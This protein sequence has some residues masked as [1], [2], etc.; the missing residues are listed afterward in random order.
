MPLSTAR[1]HG[2][3]PRQLE[4]HRERA[5][6]ASGGRAVMHIHGRGP[7]TTHVGTRNTVTRQPVICARAAAA[8]RSLRRGY[9]SGGGDPRL[10]KSDIKPPPSPSA[11]SPPRTITTLH[12]PPPPHPLPPPPPPPSPP[13]PPP[14]P[15]HRRRDAAAA[16]AAT[17]TTT[18]PTTITITTPHPTS[19]H[20]DS[21]THSTAT[22]IP[23]PGSSP[24]CRQLYRTTQTPFH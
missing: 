21:P 11:P 8:A 1:A 2:C 19:T 10:S 15:G 16:A 7:I 17:A 18:T 23:H 20:T 24:L 22:I 3:Y 12:V 14:P 13:P 4:L 9:S 5:C 6:S